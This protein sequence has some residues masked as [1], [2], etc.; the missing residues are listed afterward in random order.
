MRLRTPDGFFN[1]MCQASQTCRTG[2]GNKF[3]GGTGGW[4]GQTSFRFIWIMYVWGNTMTSVEKPHMTFQSLTQT[5]WHLKWLLKK[6][7]VACFEKKHFQKW[8]CVTSNLKALCNTWGHGSPTSPPVVRGPVSWMQLPTKCWVRFQQPATCSWTNDFRIKNFH[9]FWGKLVQHISIV[10]VVL[11]M[12]YLCSVLIGVLSW[13]FFFSVIGPVPISYPGQRSLLMSWKSW[14]KC[15]W[16]VDIVAKKTQRTNISNI[17]NSINILRVSSWHLFLITKPNCRKSQEKTKN[18]PTHHHLHSAKQHGALGQ[19][20]TAQSK[21]GQNNCRMKT[22][23]FE[24]VPENTN[25]CQS[26][27]LHLVVLSQNCYDHWIADISKPGSEKTLQSV[28]P[29]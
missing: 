20:R 24:K 1:L 2:L 26:S 23:L 11:Y 18:K 28:I 6:F 29:S 13:H 5:T 7:Y 15:P 8:H 14:R 19:S 22:G 17:S 10:L 25:M 4:K 12:L 21:Q 16:H 3:K 9:F 27:F